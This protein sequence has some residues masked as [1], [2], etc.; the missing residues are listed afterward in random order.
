[1]EYNSRSNQVSNFKL[2]ER[3]VQG[4]FETTSMIT[5]ELYDMKS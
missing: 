2:D 4:R 1:M 5:P 3:I